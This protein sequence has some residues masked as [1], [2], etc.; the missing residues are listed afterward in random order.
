MSTFP[1][2]PG[3]RWLDESIPDLIYIPIILIDNTKEMLSDIPGMEADELET[4]LTID[5]SKVCSV[6]D[7]YPVGNEGPD[8]NA[9]LVDI[10]S[11]GFI[12]EVSRKSFTKAWLF[13]KHYTR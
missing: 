2:I 8:K 1:V 5:L 4:D 6:R 11:G 10:G 9:C 7:W 3:I 13:Y 12:V